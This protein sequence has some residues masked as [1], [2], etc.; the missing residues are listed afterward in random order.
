MFSHKIDEY[1]GGF[2]G[3]PINRG[4]HCR[5]LV[6]QSRLEV[7]LPLNLFMENTALTFAQLQ[8]VA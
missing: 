5:W 7:A 3:H 4:L 8:R 2:G 1:L 6:K